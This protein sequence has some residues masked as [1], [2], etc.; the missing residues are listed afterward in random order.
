MQRRQ[1]HHPPPPHHHH[2]HHL[3]P[4]SPQRLDPSYTSV[5][6]KCICQIMKAVYN[7]L[8]IISMFCLF[9]SNENAWRVQ[10]PH[11]PDL[12]DLRV[13]VI[14]FASR[15]P[16]TGVARYVILI[17]MIIIIITIISNFAERKLLQ[18]NVKLMNHGRQSRVFWYIQPC[19]TWAIYSHQFVSLL[20]V[21]WSF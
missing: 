13:T 14:Q 1:L 16:S 10:L 2:H 5:Q 12:K 4:V 11:K 18:K 8:V 7:N 9:N 3:I 21:Y 15:L 6:T 20:N 17:I 19:Y